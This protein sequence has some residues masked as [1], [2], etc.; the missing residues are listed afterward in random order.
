[1][2]DVNMIVLMCRT[3]ETIRKAHKCTFYTIASGRITNQVAQ[4][5]VLRSATR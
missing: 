5:T 2:F 1:M 4:E 3:A